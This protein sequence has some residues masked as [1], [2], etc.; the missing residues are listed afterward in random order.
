MYINELTAYTE[1]YRVNVMSSE[2]QHY[3]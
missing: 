3:Q 1:N 2:L